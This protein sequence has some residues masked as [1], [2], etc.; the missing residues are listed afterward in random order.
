MLT[1]DTVRQLFDYDDG[2]LVWKVS[3]GRVRKGSR[4]GSINS[5]GREQIRV[6][7][8]LYLTYRIIFLMHHGYLPE[9]LDHIDG[10]LSNN[11]IENLRECTQSQNRCNS[12]GKV[13]SIT[14]VKNVFRK[15]NKYFVAVRLNGVRHYGGTFDTIEEAEQTAIQLRNELH[16]EYAR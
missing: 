16:G 12:I 8:K 3:R 5:T 14:G 6:D 1:Q 9:R 11:R 7:G 15:R 2:A 4:A 10:D 13:N